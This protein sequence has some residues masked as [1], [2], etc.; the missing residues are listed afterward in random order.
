MREEVQD[1]LG[2]DMKRGSDASRARA[3]CTAS[4]ARDVRVLDPYVESRPAARSLTIVALVMVFLSAVAASQT[5]EMR[6]IA[7]E[8][9]ATSGASYDTVP[10][11]YLP[12]EGFGGMAWGAPL[13][14]F[15]GFEPEPLAVNTA[16]SQGKV[17]DL[18]LQCAPTPNGGCDL[19]KSL[20]TLHQRV[21]GRGFHALAEYYA[22]ARGFRFRTTGAT[23]YPVLY[24]FCA[25]WNGFTDEVPSDIQQK[26][27]LCGA[28]LLFQGETR[29]DLEKIEDDDY[30]T[31]YDRVLRGLIELHGEPEGYRRRGRVIVESEDG[32]RLATTPRKRRFDEWRWCARVRGREIAPSCAASVVLAFDPASGWGVVLYAT[33]P[34]WEFAFAR[35]NGGAQDDPLYKLLH[36][37]EKYAAVNHACTGSHLCRPGPSRPMSEEGRALFRLKNTAHQRAP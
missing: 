27:R 22:E 21:G 34:V 18:D 13:D 2:E 12:P 37:L 6:A 33:R 30:L 9:A 16:Y 25:S 3:L 20:R 36:G 28:R 11:R 8:S 29:Q 26:L 19:E 4:H 15:V 24:Q 14:E 32:G 1:R 35:H 17:T 10:D 23:L 7:S 31:H 5:A